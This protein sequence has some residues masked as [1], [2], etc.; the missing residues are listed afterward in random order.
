M[1]A[2]KA[3]LSASSVMALPPYLTTMTVSWSAF[4]QGRA[5]A[6]TAAL[7]WVETGAGHGHELQAESSST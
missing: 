6:S 3:D 2:A 1:S 4:S 7:V 5:S